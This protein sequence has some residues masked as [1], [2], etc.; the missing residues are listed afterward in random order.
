MHADC[1]AKMMD[2]LLYFPRLCKCNAKVYVRL[3][4]AWIEIESVLLTPSGFDGV[5]PSGIALDDPYAFQ[6]PISR[7]AATFT[8]TPAGVSESFIVQVDAYSNADSSY[9]GS[10]L[11]HT[12]DTGSATLP[13]AGFQNMPNGSL[14]AISL[15]RMEFSSE[16]NPSTGNT[17][18]GA[19]QLGLV[20][21]GRL[22]N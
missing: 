5:E 1:F 12:E 8:W 4:V 15:L 7:S 9:L 20:G 11:C 17:I 18:Q 6:T 16:V 13:S 22:G 10:V 21:T 3:R 2:G 14:L 19:A